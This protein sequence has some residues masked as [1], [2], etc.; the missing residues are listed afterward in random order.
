MRPTLLRGTF[1]KAYQ[2]NA[3]TF[4]AF[5]ANIF[6]TMLSGFQLGQ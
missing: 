4:E 5:P 6:I 3:L 2:K 1:K